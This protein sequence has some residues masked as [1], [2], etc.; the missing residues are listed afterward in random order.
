[1]GYKWLL[2]MM[3]YGQAWK[4]RRRLFQ[5]YFSNR[6]LSVYQATQRKFVHKIL[7]GLL[8]KPKEF[9]EITQQ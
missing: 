1:M 9:L 5:K 6:N 8:E 3:V 7:P 4:E 2:P